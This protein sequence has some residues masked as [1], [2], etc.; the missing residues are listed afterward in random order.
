MLSWVIQGSPVRFLKSAISL[1]C[2]LAP[3]LATTAMPPSISPLP[4]RRSISGAP[5][6]APFDTTGKRPRPSPIS[7][8]F[9]STSLSSGT[10]VGSSS[11]T[12]GRELRTF[13]TTEVASASGGVKVSSTNSFRFSLSNPPSRIGLT[14]LIGA[15]VLSIPLPTVVRGFPVA[16]FA[17]S[18]SAGS[19]PCACAPPVGEVWNTYL[20]PRPVMTSEYDS[21]RT[22]SSAR[23]VTSVTARVK[24]DSQ[25]PLAPTTSVSC[26][27]SRCAAFFAFSA[28]SPASTTSSRMRAPPI[29]L[30][31][32]ARLMSSIAMSAPF[33]ISSPWRAHGPDI[34]AIIATRTSLACD[35]AGPALTAIAAASMTFTIV[36]IVSPP[37]R[38]T[39]HSKI[40][41]FHLFVCEQRFGRPFEDEMPRLE[42][43][44][45][46]AGSE[47]LGHALLHQQHRK[48]GLAVD[49]LDAGENLD[50]QSRRQPHGGLAEQQKPRRR[51]EA[52]ADREH[53]L[54]AAGECARRL[55]AALLEHRKQR[56]DLLEIARPSRA[57][58]VR[59]RTH[60][61][62]LEHAERP[63]HLPPFRHVSDTEMGALRRRHREQIAAFEADAARCRRHGARHRFEERRFAGAIRTDDGDELPRLP[64]QRDVDERFQPAVA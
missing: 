14:K 49:L 34:G 37:F 33:F 24:L 25:A 21:V 47:R 18:S 26:A 10:L 39:S 3:Q 13:C 5:I 55:V 2:P 36:L 62:G 35:Q 54:L 50:R 41:P 28:L 19:A 6:C 51:S 52:A 17:S 61:E 53:L 22:G 23:S 16:I 40:R 1:S 64:R 31:P 57:P 42:H 7:L 15:A 30:M 43:I 44:A 48:P 20:K 11:S 9:S 8:S 58:L 27:T 45:I 46:V 59:Q 29:D 38:K 60:L 63:D 4:T 32:P 56:V 12:S